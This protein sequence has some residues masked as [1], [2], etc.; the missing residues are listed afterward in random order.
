MYDRGANNFTLCK[1][2]TSPSNRVIQIKMD[3][4]VSY[5]CDVA[6]NKTTLSHSLY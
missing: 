2:I 5:D 4:F 1:D 6:K 3:H